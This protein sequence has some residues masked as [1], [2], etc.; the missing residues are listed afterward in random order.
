MN[1][2]RYWRNGARSSVQATAPMAARRR[3]GYRSGSWK[4][5]SSGRDALEQLFLFDD[6]HV[7]VEHR[8]AMVL[9]VDRAGA[10]CFGFAVGGVTDDLLIFVDQ[11]TVVLHGDFC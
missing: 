9:E 7:A 11:H 8:V 4:S 2:R 3:S 1:W 6:P 10:G 5:S